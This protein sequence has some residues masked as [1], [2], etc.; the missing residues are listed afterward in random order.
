MDPLS[1]NASII[2]IIQLTSAIIGSLNNLKDTTNDPAQCAIEISNVTNLL[3]R[4][5][6]RLDEASSND[7]WY[8]EVQTLVAI[9]GPIDQYKSALEQLQSN[10]TSTAS[11]RLKT[12]GSSPT[13]EFSKEEVSRILSGV[14]RLKSLIQI[15][16]GM[17]HL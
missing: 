17:D 7:P 6:S 9:D 2:A 16:L 14:E 4:L 13:W 8:T 11:S 15:A 5:M 3:V 12:S 10:F 1:V